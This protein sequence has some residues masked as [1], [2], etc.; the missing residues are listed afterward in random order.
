MPPASAP[1]LLATVL[2]SPPASHLVICYVG[3]QGIALV[4]LR[5]QVMDGN[6]VIGTLVPPSGSN[7]PSTWVQR[8]ATCNQACATNGLGDTFQQAGSLKAS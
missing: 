8:C 5:E 1:L 3:E 7:N 2:F 4:Q 6:M